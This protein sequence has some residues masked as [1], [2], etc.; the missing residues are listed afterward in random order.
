MD[1][2]VAILPAWQAQSGA[3]C[4]PHLRTWHLSE[5]RDEKYLRQAIALAKQSRTSGFHPFGALIVTDD[6]RILA[7]CESRKERGGDATQHSELTA[8]RIASGTFPKELL[9]LST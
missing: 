2:K 3:S 7:A 8:V 9:A 6:D 5:T 1:R 4:G